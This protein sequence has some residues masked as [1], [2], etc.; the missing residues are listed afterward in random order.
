MYAAGIYDYNDEGLSTV[1]LDNNMGTA[2]IPKESEE[3]VQDACAGC[4]TDAIKISDQPFCGDPLQHDK[5]Y[6]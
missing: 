1:I 6:K 4:P 2:K 3:Y 5:E